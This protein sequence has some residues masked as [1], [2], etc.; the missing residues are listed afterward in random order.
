MVDRPLIAWTIDAALASP[1][2]DRVVV[3]TDDAGIAEV[4][5]A[6]GAEVPFMRPPELAQDETPGIEPVLH[7]INWLDENQGYRTEYVM[8]L[9]PTSPLRTWQDIEKAV[10]LASAKQADSVLSVTPADNHPYRMKLVD[11]EGRMKDFRR[12]PRRGIQR[13]ELPPVYGLNGAIYLVKRQVLLQRRSWFGDR[14]YAYVME[15]KQSLDI[16]TPWDLYLAEL[17]LRDRQKSCRETG[18]V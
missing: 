4:A 15:P 9:Q 3:S 10:E 18:Q 17:I 6:Q 7:G 8:L 14:T 1:S 11:S 16:D 13:Q 12:A 2:I 5:R